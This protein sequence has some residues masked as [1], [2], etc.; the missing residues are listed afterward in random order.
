MKTEEL[1]TPAPEQDAAEDARLENILQVLLRRIR[2][3]GDEGRSQ[4]KVLIKEFI[5]KSDF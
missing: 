1:E 2:D 5:E 4:V 3:R